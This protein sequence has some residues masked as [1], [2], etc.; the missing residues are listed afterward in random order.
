MRKER[1]RAVTCSKTSSS[2]F[3]ADRENSNYFRLPPVRLNNAIIKKKIVKGI[4]ETFRSRFNL[5]LVVLGESNAAFRFFI[6]P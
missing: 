1:I 2:L 3:A 5:P 4:L 6:W